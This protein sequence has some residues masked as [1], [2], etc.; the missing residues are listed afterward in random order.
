[1]TFNVKADNISLKYKDFEAVKNVSFTLEEGKT[2]GLIGRNG[3]GKTSLL[4]ILAS[5]QESNSGTLT[6]GGE[7]PFE[8]RNVMPHVSFMYESDYSDEY[9]PVKSYFEF[10]ERY[11]PKFDRAY[12][13]ELS[14]SFRLPLDKPIKQLSSGMQS[15]LNATIGL[16][17]RTPVTILDE[18]YL[19]MDA[20]TR[21]V[22]Y[23]EVIEEQA[24]HPRIMILSTHLVSE[25]EYL[26][27]HVLI[28]HNGSL[29]INEPIDEI[30]SRGATVTGDKNIVDDFV[31]GM[32]QINT[33]HLGN[34]KAVMIYEQLSEDKY[35][36]AQRLGLEVGPVSLQELFIHLTEED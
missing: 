19:A 25:M 20:P 17:S 10:A 7:N 9:E 33:Q 21:E 32:R 2:Y 22:F 24:R 6:I 1:M 35:V 26:F 4:S 29:L 11:R 3:A 34:T 8:N 30:V 36:E 16:A 23:K 18:V 28:L 13:E 15:A 5:F 14:A 27:D 31:K 12:A